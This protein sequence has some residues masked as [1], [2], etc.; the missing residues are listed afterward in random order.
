MKIKSKERRRT[1]RNFLS[2]REQMRLLLLFMSLGLV[3]LAMIEASKP[4]NWVWVTGEINPK[5]EGPEDIDTAYQGTPSNDKPADFVRIVPSGDADD[6]DDDGMGYFP[7][8]DRRA[9]KE[10]KDN[11]PLIRHQDAAAWFNLWQVLSENDSRILKEASIGEI[12]FTQIYR[13]TDVY[14]GQLVTISGGVRRTTEA[15]FG[16]NKFGLKAYHE[17]L[18]RMD[19]G[20]PQPVF[21]YAMHLPEGFPVGN[22]LR[23][24]EIEVTGFVYKR[25]PHTGRNGEWVGPVLLARDFTWFPSD[26]GN[27]Q[28]PGPAVMFGIVSSAAAFALLVAVGVFIRSRRLF[29][30]SQLEH[31]RTTA[32]NAV[33][34]DEIEAGP[35]LEEKF[36]NLFN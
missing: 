21:V 20:P 27:A 7:S 28:L 4:E 15:E 25:I 23:F 31:Q 24:E 35:T 26:R 32:A 13:Q 14:R 6:D 10:V 19:D 17:L 3:V 9:L 16:K 29:R 1:P 12:S 30:G 11:T 2:R 22:K 8:V 33:S 18:L 34:F 36:R 5:T